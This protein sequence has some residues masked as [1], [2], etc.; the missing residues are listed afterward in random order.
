MTDSF[1]RKNTR[2]QHIPRMNKITSLTTGQMKSRSGT[3]R[4]PDRLFLHRITQSLLHQNALR[5]H[6]LWSAAPDHLC[7]QLENR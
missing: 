4:V 1:F 7:V 3:L 6:Q 5:F 2:G